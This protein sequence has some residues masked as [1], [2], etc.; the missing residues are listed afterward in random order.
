MKYLVF[1]QLISESTFRSRKLMSRS[2]AAYNRV[3]IFLSSLDSNNLSVDIY[4]TGFNKQACPR[5]IH[6]YPAQITQICQHLRFLEFPAVT[7][8]GK[9]LF[10]PLFLLFSLF[11]LIPSNSNVVFYNYEMKYLLILFVSC[12]MRKRIILLLEEITLNPECECLEAR[13][14]VRRRVFN[15]LMYIYLL[16]ATRVVVPSAN[17]IDTLTLPKSKVFV[18]YGI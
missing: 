16:L 15:L 14:M 11:R 12:L 3:L 2:Q 9:N 17:F 6:F 1:A 18:F 4:S 8:F 7:V 5:L 10:L 13:E